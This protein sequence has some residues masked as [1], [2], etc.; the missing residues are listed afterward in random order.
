MIF[1]P[2]KSKFKKQQ[3]GRA[4]NKIYKNVDYDQ[5]NLGSVG[6]K[7][8]DFGRIT[9]KQLESTRQSI[10]KII[11]KSGRVI[12]NI[13]PDTPISKK[14]VEIR[15]GKGKGNVDHWIF[16]VQPGC[17]ICEIETQFKSLALKALET[18]QTRFPVKTRI[19]FN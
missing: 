5:L 13:Y 6:L 4:F 9:S 15:M 2:K 10:N 14:P 18:A 17:V 7:A 11:K 19:V 12:V 1:V 16:K 8:L 3:K